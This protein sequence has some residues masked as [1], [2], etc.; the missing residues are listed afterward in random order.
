MCHTLTI[1]SKP[2]RTPSD[3]P[4]YNP[5]QQTSPISQV[6]ESDLYLSQGHI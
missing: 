5:P 6:S 2:M 4:G 3:L 1:F